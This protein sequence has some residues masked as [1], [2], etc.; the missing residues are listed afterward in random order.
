MSCIHSIDQVLSLSAVD[1][2]AVPVGRGSMR[3]WR[4]PSL[5]RFDFACGCPHP[6]LLSIWR[7]R[8]FT[9]GSLRYRNVSRRSRWCNCTTLTG[10]RERIVL[11]RLDTDTRRGLYKIK[12][13]ALTPR[14]Y[15]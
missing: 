11:P 6:L 13:H 3:A 4:L 8:Y 15:S 10:R 14:P 7:Y 12:G 5:L 9:F 1:R 2:H